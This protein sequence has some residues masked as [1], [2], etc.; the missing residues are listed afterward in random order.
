MSIPCQGLKSR[1][2]TGGTFS[3]DIAALYPSRAASPRSAVWGTMASMSVEAATRPV[4]VLAADAGSDRVPEMAGLAHAAGRHVRAHALAGARRRP[5]GEAGRSE[6]LRQELA[7]VGDAVAEALADDGTL[8]LLDARAALAVPEMMRVLLD[9]HGRGWDEAWARVQDTMRARLGSPEPDGGP[10]VE[11]GLL[12]KEC[13]RV[14]ELLYEINRRHLDAAE[15]HRP[16]DVAHRR[17]VSLFR[18]G[19]TKRLSLC[20]LAVVGSARAEVAP[21]WEGEA[22]RTL[23]DVREL[24]GGAV[25]PR[26]T[27][28]DGRR[29]LVEA[30]PALAAALTLA[31]GEGWPGEPDV[32]ARLETLAF[33]AA[34]R[35]AFRSARRAAR[36]R[37]AELLRATLGLETDPDA[38]VDVRFGSLRGRERPLLNVLGVVREHLRITAGGWTPP[39]PRTVVIA[40]EAGA[41][42][43]GVQRV[44]EVAR[45]VAEVVNADERARGVLRVAVL[46]E[47]P[48]PTARLLA[49]A[50][51]LSNQP[52]TAGS[53]AAGTHA[54]ALALGGALTLGTRDGTVR[55]LESALG[56]ENLFLFGLAP[57]ETRA[58]SEGRFYRPQDVYAIDPLVR[59]SLDALVSSRYAPA[60]GAFDW[61]REW[62][63]DPH[64]PWLVLADLGA[65]VHRQDEALAEFADPRAFTEKAIFTVARCRRFWADPGSLGP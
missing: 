58:W 32:L 39:A 23:A 3:S 43:P 63:L 18:E 4:H 57:R 19:E 53:G 64:D 17:R 11:V 54:L 7:L 10:D 44:L 49:G 13:P 5:A 25:V 26:P 46:G 56:A 45:A 59:L 33:D 14:L 41:S 28:V 35:G 34:F 30:R 9:E 51:D 52:G 16:G 38:L 20:A 50:A 40:R 2:R 22:G 60:S 65:Y 6:R 62:L 8:V 61:V 47:C 12:E 36:E 21:P 27:P 42:V 48:E 29:W 24:R 1:S 15:E 37:L 55:E 31:L